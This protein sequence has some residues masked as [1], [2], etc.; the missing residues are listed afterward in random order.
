MPTLHPLKKLLHYASA[1]RRDFRLAMLYSVLNKFFDVL[2]EV[3]IGV[4]VDIVVNGEKSF[5]AK[6]VLGGFGIVDTWH[7]LI[8]LGV[9]NAL[10]WGG[11]S[12]FEY[13][14]SL[15]W[16]KLAQN[17]QHDLRLDTYDHV[18]K[19]D[20]AYFENQ[21]TGNLMSILNEDINQMER[22]LNGGANQILQVLCSSIMVSAV[23]FALQPALAVIALLPVPAILFG[24]FWFQRRL[25]PRYAEVREAAGDVSA[26]LNNNLLGLATI[27]AYATEAFETAHIA[28]ASNTYREANARAIAVSAAITPVIRMAIL[29]GFSATLVY[30]GWLTLHGELAVGAYSVLVYL[31]QRLLW[32]MTGLADVADMY[33]R[34]MSAIA[35]TMNLLDTKISIPYEGQHLP[36][37]QVR[38]E[39]RFE[40]LSF[41]YGE[42]ATLTAIDLHIPAG[43]TVAF[44]GAT[45]SGKSTL[46]KLLLR[47]YAPQSG[48]ILLDGCATDSLNL[49]DLRRAIA[50]V[51]QDSF[52]TDGSI[53][54]NIAYGVEGAS[55]AAIAAAAEAA[56]ALEF[57]QRLP[58]GFATRIGERG[59]KLSGG[60]RQRLALA[61]AI[62]KNPAI[63]IL[64][65]ATS[66]VD[67]ETEAAIQ[68]SLDVI[69]RD[70]T[71]LIIA[72]RLS[73][74]R[75]ADCIYVLEAG[76][77]IESGSHQTLLDAN[78]AYAALWR[79]QTGQ[80][81]GELT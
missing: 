7:Q 37:N 26:R 76:S 12:W 62:L 80:R 67:N 64:D 58:L 17:L 71:T 69:S 39:L 72:H 61:R 34:S 22:F 63:L 46:V 55:D 28:E 77:I 44:V 36:A 38:G 14:L 10:I 66:A 23:F 8:F 52:L 16:R 41:A 68:R 47:F 74:V 51:A 70:R 20:M 25:A 32:P 57:I 43:H 53:A 79:L 75:H 4:A 78:G 2:P 18:Q 15:K 56:E 59:Q 1:Y 60:Q 24:A 65:E 45:G 21:R 35:R 5:L 27:K 73:T 81:D 19:L 40:A 50:Y 31:T 13:L 11:E 54:E 9:V 33:Q 48:R 30:G 29:A 3:L 6:R 49:Q 42:Q